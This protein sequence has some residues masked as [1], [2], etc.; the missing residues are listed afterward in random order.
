[1]HWRVATL[2][3]PTHRGMAKFDVQKVKVVLYTRESR[4]PSVLY[5]GESGLPSVLAPKS[6]FTVYVTLEALFTAFKAT[7]LKKVYN[8]AYNFPNTKILCFKNVHSSH[9]FINSLVCLLN[10]NG[11]K[12]LLRQPL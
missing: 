12:I 3:G 8:I 11:A 9:M 2:Q 4:L 1:M 10:K 6:Q 7:L 5:T